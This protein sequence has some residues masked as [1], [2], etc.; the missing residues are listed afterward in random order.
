VEKSQLDKLLKL[1]SD[2]E[3]YQLKVFYNASIKM[4]KEYQVQS[5]STKLKD[6]QGAE[7]ALDDFAG[8]LQ[9]RYM[10]ET[11]TFSNRLAVTK[12][13]T[14]EG[15]KVSK[16]TVYNRTGKAKLLPREDGLFHLKDVNKYAG[17]FLKRKDTGKR[18][19]TEQDNLQRRK[20][21]LE[22]EKLE[23][24]IARAKH[25]QKVEEGLYI[26]RD[27]FEIELASRATVLDAGIAHF[28][29]SDAA[30]WIHLVGGDQRKLPELISV[31][32]AAKDEFMNQYA[33]A[34]EF[35]VE[36]GEETVDS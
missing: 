16:S 6:L 26:P 33:R 1:A 2:E 27:Q 4:L 28:F 18:L 34:R 22:V 14:V 35:V 5:T 30:T 32:M 12:Y 15:W 31:L 29:Q 36:I 21:G 3:Q 13:L 20:T 11:R 23:V 9:E 17:V 10:P 19:Q 25:K 8:R 7:A 24:E